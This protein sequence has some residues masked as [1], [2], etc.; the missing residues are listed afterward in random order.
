MV[1]L[2]PQHGHSMPAELSRHGQTCCAMRVVVELLTCSSLMN[3]QRSGS[4]VRPVDPDMCELFYCRDGDRTIWIRC[5]TTTRIAVL[6]TSYHC[7]NSSVSGGGS[8][9]HSAVSSNIQQPS[10]GLINAETVPRPDRRVVLR[11]FLAF[12]VL[13]LWWSGEA[14][15]PRT[16]IWW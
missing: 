10:A 14:I 2:E 5:R 15:R 8:S 11:C 6:V 1:E 9:V 16:T 13:A 3:H 12:A 4:A 7:G